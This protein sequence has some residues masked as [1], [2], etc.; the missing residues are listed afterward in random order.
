MAT[1]PIPYHNYSKPDFV[2]PN[3]EIKEP[4][5]KKPDLLKVLVRALY[6]RK[7]PHVDTPKVCIVHRDDVLTLIKESTNHYKISTEAG[8]EGYVAKPFVDFYEQHT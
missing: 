5:E 2:D 1:Q 8:D 7:G 6:V 3:V 4:V